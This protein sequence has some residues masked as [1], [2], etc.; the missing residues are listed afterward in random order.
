MFFN[1]V[2]S[3]SIIRL[4]M[5]VQVYW[6]ANVVFLVN[7]R[8]FCERCFSEHP[9][10][11]F[12][13]CGIDTNITTTFK[14]HIHSDDNVSSR[15]HNKSHTVDIV[16]S[17]ELT[18]YIVSIQKSCHFYRLY[19]RFLFENNHPFD[20]AYKTIHLTKNNNNNCEITKICIQ[21]HIF[22]LIENLNIPT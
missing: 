21:N 11:A 16:L 1:N 7:S 9:T 15:N 3:Y 2:F 12:V 8:I 6:T 18:L 5:Y 20:R 10:V 14:F 22:A 13:S 17:R 19:F 4:C